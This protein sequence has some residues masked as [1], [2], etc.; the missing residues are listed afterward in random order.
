MEYSTHDFGL[1]KCDA[2]RVAKLQRLELLECHGSI[3][4]KGSRLDFKRKD[5]HAMSVARLRLTK[6]MTR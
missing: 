1:V 5:T 3:P 4:A 6:N 2:E